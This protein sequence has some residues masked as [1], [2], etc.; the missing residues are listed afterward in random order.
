MH[1][2]P[3]RLIP[4]TGLVW[5][6]RSAARGTGA[7]WLAT[8]EERT[9]V[10]SQITARVGRG[11][12][13]RRRS[14]GAAALGAQDARSSDALAGEQQ[15]PSP[16][17]AGPD[18][19]AMTTRC[20]KAPTRGGGQDKRSR[21]RKRRRAYQPGVGRNPGTPK[22]QGNTAPARSQGHARKERR[23]DPK[24]R[25]PGHP[26]ERGPEDRATH[27]P[28]RGPNRQPE[29]GHRPPG[30]D[31]YPVTVPNS[32]ANRPLRPVAA[33]L[34][35]LRRSLPAPY[36]R[37]SFAVRHVTRRVSCFPFPQASFLASPPCIRGGLNAIRGGLSAVR[38][39]ARV[40]RSN[41][42]GKSHAVASPVPLP[43]RRPPA[44]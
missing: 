7:R 34:P 28:T 4:Y 14:G 36:S 17:P 2:W 12:G 39:R 1:E 16:E 3:R 42:S 18:R 15:A 25:T 23:E 40:C 30:P 43:R 22:R 26:Q 19:R 33:G 10:P 13:G 44:G 24:D 5:A 11:S 35:A 38:G 9:S 32:A 8:A 29:Q 37:P 21:P 20:C 6:A 27:T 31:L 41:P